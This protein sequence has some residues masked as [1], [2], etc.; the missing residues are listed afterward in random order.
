MHSSVDAIKSWACLTGKEDMQN[1]D[2]TGCL[3]SHWKDKNVEKTAKVSLYWQTITCMNN[4]KE[5]NLNKL[6]KTLT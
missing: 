5:L 6:S 3:Q 1:D 4:G 2:R